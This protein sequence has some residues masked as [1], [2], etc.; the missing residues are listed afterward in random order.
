MTTLKAFVSST[1]IDLQAHRRRV[2]DTLR[3]GK[4]HVDPMENWTA[5]S[6]EPK[7][8]SQERMKDCDLC[9]LLVAFRKGYVPDGES[10]SITQME[11]R[12]AVEHDI[13]VLVFVL[14]EAETNWPFDERNTDP[15]IGRW[16]EELKKKHGVGSFR[17][18]PASLDVGPAVLRW[19]Q[20]REQ[21]PI[22]TSP[23]DFTS[24]L[25]SKRQG[26]VGREWLFAKIDDWRT[27]RQEK[28]LL[29]VGDPGIGKSAIAAELVHRNPGGQVLAHHCCR[30][31]DEA[32]LQAGL[33]VRALA[34][35]AAQAARRLPGYAA[36]LN[37]PAIADAISESSCMTNP[38]HA[39]D[40]GL[41]TPLSR[42]PA[43]PQGVCYLVIDA[44]DEALAGATRGVNV[45][46][47]LAARL[48]QL[49]GWLRIVATTRR[50]PAVLQKLRG[51]RPWPLEAQDVPN[52]DDVRRYVEERLRA[53]PVRGLTP[54]EGVRLLTQKAAGN[55]LWVQQALAGLAG[56]DDPRAYL[57]RLPAGL[58]G[59][60][61]RFFERR[62]A[63]EMVYEPVRRLWQVMIAA[64]QPLTEKQLSAVT[65]LHMVR[66]LPA[67]LRS[68]SQFVVRRPQQGCEDVYAVYHKSL[69]DWLTDDETRRDTTW[70]ADPVEGRERLANWCWSEYQRGPR[71]MDGYALRHLPAHLI[72]T[73]RWDD[74]AALLTDLS[75]LE[76]KAETGLVFDLA[77]DFGAAVK[78]LPGEHSW[79]RRLGLLHEA[80]GLDLAFLGRHPLALFQTLWNRCWWYDCPQAAK[81]YCQAPDKRT[82]PWDTPG[83][84]LSELLERWRKCKNAAPGFR[85][86]RLLRPPSHHL[87]TA[88]RMIL[89]GH[90]GGV[91][92]V[93]VSPDGKRLASGSY[94]HTVRLWDAET[95]LEL[96]RLEGHTESVTSV[97]FS[98]DGKRLA[99]GSYDKTVR[100]WDA[101]TG[102]ELR[103]LE[104]HTDTVRSVSFSADGKR[105]AS[106]SRDETVRLWDAET[107]ECLEVIEG[108]TDP[109][110]AARGVD[111]P[112]R[113]VREPLETVIQDGKT[114]HAVAWIALTPERITTHSSGRI[115]AGS[116]ADYVCLFALEGD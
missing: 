66:E 81:Y 26:F 52:Q 37:E 23:F 49:P 34:A 56:E 62:F 68:V 22:L 96:R 74:L 109:F 2:I 24:H 25:E 110:A 106:G 112:W 93:A 40:H 82:P 10:I 32:T 100:L 87:G 7:E 75:Y 98:G 57:E 90:E 6:S 103:R 97:S 77:G 33:V 41:L 51:L 79:H 42:L 13:D 19:I 16:R 67:L 30:W 72:E 8:F 43:P 60:Y 105:L 12:Y 85:W 84:R 65:G 55:F 58:A 91:T 21:K 89:A 15:E 47:M 31:D 1:F 104:G 80:L 107:G 46:E 29:L 92:S 17:A 114:G 95:G 3:G 28:S 73:Q 99:S 63:D 86:L 48:E 54:G 83:P 14:D 113:A 76:T 35:Q 36:L 102:L 94:D 20:E 4:V 61:L 53:E 59:I 71:K 70:Y 64:R 50:E 78:A 11:Y 27:K 116:I 108:D 101:E 69:T 115:W 18:D 111:F 45:V 44:L 38:V 5:T 88:L 9:I 39:Y